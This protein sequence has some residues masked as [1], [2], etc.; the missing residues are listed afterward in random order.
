MDEPA[1]SPPLD[2]MLDALRHVRRRKR[3][4]APLEDDPQDDSP[5]VATRSESEAKSLR[6]LVEMRH[7]HLPKLEECGFVVWNREAQEVATGPD[8]AEIRPLLEL[9]DDHAGGTSSELVL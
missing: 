7:M 6:R 9:L 1:S 2:T 5:V 8:F 3:T 4:V